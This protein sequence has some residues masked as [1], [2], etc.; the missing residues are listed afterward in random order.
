MRSCLRLLV[1]TLA[2]A[3]AA[4]EAAVLIE[5]RQGGAAMRIVADR[6]SERVLV[7]RGGRAALVDL[8]GG[9]VYRLDQGEGPLRIHARFRPGH[10][11]L[12]PYRVEAFGPGPIR[13]GHVT[14]YHV[15]FA[16]DEVCAEVLASE[17]MLPFV[18]PA[19]RALSELEDL[20]G[21]SA[22]PATP[23]AAIPITTLAATGWPLLVG[24]I[25]HPTFETISIRFDYEPG[26]DE[27]A[28]PAPR[29]ETAPV[30]AGEGEPRR[31]V[32]AAGP[33]ARP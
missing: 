28:L 12:A 27:L 30:A 25:D 32:P 7:E 14:T 5:A 29:G 26:P 17:W 10:G 4:G 1:L 16:Q 22:Q 15:L 21:R 31:V 20:E 24:K 9:A 23:C 19:V 3:P 6:A 33:K 11:Q 2:I 13:A 18:D 8:A